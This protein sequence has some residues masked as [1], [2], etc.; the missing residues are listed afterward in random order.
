MT[1]E[2]GRNLQIA[3]IVIALILGWW[4]YSGKRRS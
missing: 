1:I 4:H 3:A 2:I